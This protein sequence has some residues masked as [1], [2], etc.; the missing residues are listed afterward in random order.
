MF[1]HQHLPRVPLLAVAFGLAV[2]AAPADGWSQ[3]RTTQER[4]ERLER[5]LNMLQRQVYRGG[6]SPV[7]PGDP[8]AAV[9]AQIRMDRIETQM[10]DLTGQIEEFINRLEQLR[11]R[12]EQI[13]ADFDMRIGT[14]TAAGASPLASAGPRP[15]PPPPR[16]P[17]QFAAEQPQG[18]DDEPALRHQPAGS[19]G[20]PL[21][22]G[23]AVPP[24][25]GPPPVYGTLTPPGTPAPG[26]E[27]TSVAPAARPPVGEALPSGSTTDQYNY[28]FGLLK[29]ADYP[30]AETALKAFIEQH[31]KDPMAGNAQYWLGETYYTRNR[32]LEAASAFAEGY[33]RWPK[34]P[35]AADDLLKLGM[36]LSRANQKQNAC[37]AFAQLDRDFPNP[38]A[39]IKER[40]AGEKKHLGC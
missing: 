38:G 22:P 8:G 15:P 17:R 18:A 19:P 6:P 27:L 25:A 5:D 7:I 12:V 9:N 16:P 26:P 28:A 1:R 2:A 36:S 20:F 31:P 33:K 11:Q 4:I 21:P 39:A 29:Q 14:G 37:L 23:A 13:Y 10:R 24:P 35:K 3:D 30:A 40:A 34:S 32:F